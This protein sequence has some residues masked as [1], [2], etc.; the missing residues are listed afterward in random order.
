MSHEIRTP[1]HGIMG[2]N[3][4][5]LREAQDENIR[6]YAKNIKNASENLLEIINGI[7]DFSKIE[8]GKIEMEET[9]YSLRGLLDDVVNM[10]APIARKKD[11]DFQ[12]KV[13]ENLPSELYGDV[14]KIRQIIVNLLNNAVKYT[15]TGK[16]VL[17]IRGAFV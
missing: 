15:K 6:G 8:V 3:E 13:D 14:G 4:M 16:V 9:A 5:V 17:T 1:I 11:L 10:I 12:V 2:M 7:L